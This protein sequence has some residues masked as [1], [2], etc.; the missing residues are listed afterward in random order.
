MLLPINLEFDVK[1]PW[2]RLMSWNRQR[3]MQTSVLVASIASDGFLP[4]ILLSTK[5][6]P[7]LSVSFRSSYHPSTSAIAAFHPVSFPSLAAF[8]LSDP[9]LPSI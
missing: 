9:H 5:A 2:M 6:V 1:M 3:L 4:S 8:T 7:L